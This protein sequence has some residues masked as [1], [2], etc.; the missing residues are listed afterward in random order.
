[1][2]PARSIASARCPANRYDLSKRLSDMLILTFDGLTPAALSCY[3]SSWNQTRWLDRLAA[4]GTAWDR[5]VTPTDDPLEQLVRWF[6]DP[7]LPAEQTLL[8]TDATA[9]SDHPAADRFAEVVLVDS[10]AEFA[11]EA[12]EETVLGRLAAVA[13]ARMEDHAH[14]WLHSSF[15]T[16]T[17]DAP[18]ELFPVEDL[19]EDSQEWDEPEDPADWRPLVEEEAGPEEAPPPIFNGITPPNL[20]LI[21][22]E[23]PDLVTAWMRT[24]G[25]QVRLIDA[26]LGVL[27]PI[28]RSAP[29]LVAGTSGF[30]LGQNGAV[31]HR[32][33]P[34]RSYHLRVPIL[35]SDGTGIRDPQLKSADHLARVIDMLDQQKSGH[36]TSLV[37]PTDWAASTRD[38]PAVLTHDSQGVAALTDPQWYFHLADEALFLKPDDTDDVNDVARLEPQVAEHLRQRLQSFGQPPPSGQARSSGQPPS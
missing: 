34:L 22:D 20:L 7:R 12:V 37:P 16:T 31:G 10:D 2:V 14:V 13:A 23:H 26:V 21:G 32:T 38:A 18:R 25:C 36:A 30:A 1:M 11:A 8:V 28:A 24:Y 29:V 35:A 17:W 19:E 9:V 15:L 27:M 33:G 6:A 4:T 5:V 3:G